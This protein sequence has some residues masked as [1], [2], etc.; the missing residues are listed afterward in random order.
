MSVDGLI[1]YAVGG[2]FLVILLLTFIGIFFE[3]LEYAQFIRTRNPFRR[4]CKDCGARHE[5]MA[6]NDWRLNS[7]YE[8]RWWECI[9]EGCDN[10]KP[11]ARSDILPGW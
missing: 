1:F 4:I 8:R 10:C 5:L 11:Y 7:K 2:F 3:V 6:L 9:G